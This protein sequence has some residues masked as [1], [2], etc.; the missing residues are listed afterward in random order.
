VTGSRK[1]HEIS[2]IDNLLESVLPEVETQRSLGRNVQGLAVTIGAMEL[3][4]EE[5][6][7]QA[8]TVQTCDTPLAGARLELTIVQ[9]EA[10]CPSC[11]FHGPLPDDRIDPHNPDPIMEC[12]A[13]SAPA[14]VEGGRGVQK[15][16]LLLAE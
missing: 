12:P 3:H 10:Q 14:A 1:V 16:E 8:F 15:V 9:P 6:F 13:C 4:S 5:A 11:G 7:R 2:L